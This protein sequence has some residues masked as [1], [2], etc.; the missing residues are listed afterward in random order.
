M[1]I[2]NAFC[3]LISISISIL[4]SISVLFSV[5]TYAADKSV[6]NDAD[7]I[8]YKKTVS[9]LDNNR[10]NDGPLNLARLNLEDILKIYPRYAPAH[11]EMAR[12]YIIDGQIN[13]QKGAWKFSPGSLENAEKAIKKAVEID[14]DFA[15]AYVLFGHL[16]RLMLRPQEAIAALK[17]AEKLTTSDPWLH[18]NWA[19]LLMDDRKD[20]QAA[21]H[22]EKVLSNPSANRKAKITAF[23]GLNSYYLNTNNLDKV[24]MLFKQ[25]I[26]FDPDGAWGYGNYAQFLLCKKDDY[27]GAILRSKEALNIMD[28]G[29]ARYWLSAALYRKWVQNV[30]TGKTDIGNKALIEAQ[31][32]YPNLNIQGTNWATC[33][34]MQTVAKALKK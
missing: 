33:L 7:A 30:A 9:I 6:L 3:R 20:D 21:S 24:D 1:K 23:E 8:K 5:S 17:K 13:Y 27:E 19:D 29:A 22:Y 34:P 32:V 31:Q 26:Q 16:Y 14:P 12:Y 10:G 28:Y 15:E 11:R 4:I 25:R 2:H 18:N